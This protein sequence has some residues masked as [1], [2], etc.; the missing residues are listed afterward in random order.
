M[1]A[2]IR[3]LRRGVF[4]GC[5]LICGSA[6]MGKSA[7]SRLL[8]G[9]LLCEDPL[10]AGRPCGQCKGCRRVQALTHP[11]LLTPADTK[12]KS[13]G[14]E[15]IRGILSALQTHALESDRRAVLLD[16]ADRLT[17]QAQNSLLKN[18]EEHPPATHFILTTAYETRLLSTIRSRVVTVRLA[19]MGEEALT[20]WLCAQGLD[21]GHAREYARLSDGSPGLALTLSADTADQAMRTLVYETLFSLEDE[22]GIPDIEYRLKDLK[23]DFDRFLSVTERELRLVMR[24]AADA[25]LSGRWANARPARLAGILGHVIRAEQQRASNVNYQAVLNVLLQS[26]V[27]D[28]KK[29]PSS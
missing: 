4:P 22:A 24:G 8:A 1:A 5:V 15:E 28:L 27:E 7:L 9:A 11:D 10:P 29:W 21:A 26:I 3:E 18:L 23:D 6:G 19:P 17:V 20:D 2:L 25:R 16:D 12:K 13:I 14:V